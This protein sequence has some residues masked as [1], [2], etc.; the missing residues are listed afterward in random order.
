MLPILAVGF[1][2]YSSE[3]VCLLHLTIVGSRGGARITMI[4]TIGRGNGVSTIA[5]SGKDKVDI[6]LAP[7]R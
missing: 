2:M 4:A 6:N 7:M 3:P 1:T 5:M